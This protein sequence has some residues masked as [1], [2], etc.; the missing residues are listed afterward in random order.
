MDFLVPSLARPRSR[1]DVPALLKELGFVVG[2]RGRSGVMLLEHPELMVEFLVPER[3]RGGKEV[4]ALP[5]LGVNA[6]PLRL[7]DIATMKTVRLHFE[8]V[9]VTA[10]HPAAFALHKILVAPRR[11]G[12][13]KKTK[14]LDAALLV[15]ERLEQHGELGVVRDLVAS[16]PRPWRK[17]VLSTLRQNRREALAHVI[18]KL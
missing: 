17:I 4:Q 5:Q 14:D 2:F 15:L 1:V 3:G 11:S 12:A 10:P 18:E 7:L 13:E 6:Q 16:F 9:L 8:D